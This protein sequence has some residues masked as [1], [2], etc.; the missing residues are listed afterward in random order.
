MLDFELVWGMLALRLCALAVLELNVC[1][2]IVD[3]GSIAA[4]NP[5]FLA[6][7]AYI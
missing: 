1:L 4:L 2:H 3:G 6:R 5:Y 7:R